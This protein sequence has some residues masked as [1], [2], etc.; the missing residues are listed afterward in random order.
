MWPAFTEE[1]RETVLREGRLEQPSDYSDE[2]EIITRKLIE[3]ADNHLIMDQP[4]TF[5]C[6]VRILQGMM[7]EAVPWRHALEFADVIE[8]TDLE[9]LLTKTGDHRL[10][11]PEDL[12][13][14]AT[15]LGAISKA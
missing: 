2:P 4:L 12:T 9:V 10:S 13:R 8:S 11:T 15:V 5:H 6:P 7:D 3:E 14:L 1:Q